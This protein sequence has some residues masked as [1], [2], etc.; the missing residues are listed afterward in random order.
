[1]V[2]ELIICTDSPIRNIYEFEQVVIL[3]KCCGP[4]TILAHTYR[5]LIKEVRPFYP[6]FDVR[7]NHAPTLTNIDVIEK[8]GADYGILRH[9][10]ERG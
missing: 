5:D 2:V 3:T 1:M 7:V 10:A 8:E 4:L 6:S 9:V